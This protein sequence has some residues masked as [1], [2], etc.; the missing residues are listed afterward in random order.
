MERPQ[1]VFDPATGEPSHLATAVC[2]GGDTVGGAACHFD[3]A[4]WGLYRP[5][6]RG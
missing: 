4:S 3:I 1:L 5:V 6:R 2:P